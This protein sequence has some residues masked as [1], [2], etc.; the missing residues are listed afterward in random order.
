MPLKRKFQVCNGYLL[1]FDQLAR[2]LDFMAENS[3]AGK[4]SRQELQENTGL[5]NR[6]IA[7]LV[8]VGSAMG[9]IQS[10][11]QILTPIG[12]L[13]AKYDTFIEAKGS[14]EW[15]HYTGAGSYGNL[16]WYEIF[17]TLLPDEQPMTQKGWMKQLRNALAGQYTD[18]TIGKHLYEEVRLV[19]D[20]YLNRNFNK[21]DLL[22]QDSDG[23]LYHKRYAKPEPTV[24]AAMLYDYGE[25]IGSNVLQI[26]DLAEKAGAIGVLFAMDKVCLRQAV[27]NLHERGWIRYEGTHNLDQLRLKEGY[28]ASELMKAY[29]ENREPEIGQHVSN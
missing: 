12:A 3:S 16:I 7:S 1:E 15:C 5:S 2:V 22:H 8:S 9:V 20:A 19:I 13:I 18:R 28:T 14:L 24:L 10:G 26:H 27:E 25:R 6:Q 17:N 21:L 4:I 11:K 29:Y 23:I